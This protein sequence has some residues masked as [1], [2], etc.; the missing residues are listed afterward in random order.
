MKWSILCA[1]V[2]ERLPRSGHLVH[3]LTKQLD[4]YDDIEFLM[5]TDNATMRLGEKR[6]LLLSLARG[7]YVN[8][9]DD[10]D[11]VSDDYVATI[12]PLLDG[13]DYIGFEVAHF[14]KGVRTKPVRHSLEYKGWSEDESGFYRNISHLNPIRTVIAKQFEFYGAF[15]EDAD[16]GKRV[17]ESGLVHTQHFINCEMYYYYADVN[18]SAAY[19]YRDKEN[20]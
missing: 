9:V 17:F 19:K 3:R 4:K 14:D 20:K 6:N 13:V 12:Y 5:L 16:W 8:F 7:Q 15:G 1:G 18:K 11:E 2:T 10:D